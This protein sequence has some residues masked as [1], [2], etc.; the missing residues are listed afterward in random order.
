M[1]LK[2]IKNQNTRFGKKTRASVLNE[3]LKLFDGTKLLLITAQIK[4]NLYDDF[5]II[6]KPFENIYE[7]KKRMGPG[8]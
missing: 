2:Y 5:K 8:M 3:K 6:V 1:F 7:N 4:Y